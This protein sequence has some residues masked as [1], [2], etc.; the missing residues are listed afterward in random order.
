[1]KLSNIQV[2]LTT[3]NEELR[4]H[5]VLDHLCRHCSNIL[6]IDNLSTDKTVEILSSCYPSVNVRTLKNNGTSETAEW[7]REARRS[8][9]LDY[10]VFASCSEYLPLE[11]LQL[12]NFYAA[13]AAVQYIH[14]PRSSFTNGESLDDLYIT[15]SS[16][17]SREARLPYV[18]RCVYVDAVDPA[19][20]SPHDAFRSQ[21]RGQ[22]LYVDDYSGFYTIV[23]LRP[24]P[25]SG[26]FKKHVAYAKNYAKLKFQHKPLSAFLDTF[27]R[28]ILDTLRLI[29]SIIIRHSLHPIVKIE[30]NARVFMHINVFIFAVLS[31]LPSSWENK[32]LRN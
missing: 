21:T 11:L 31:C 30:Y 9:N 10:V 18:C 12:Y 24:L 32:L 2:V 23:H 22:H 20:I 25:S 26:L 13:Q 28:I 1:M 3:Y 27:L 19:L 16:L 8:F 29:R 14:V 5:S 7:W 15:P 6:V 4:V 17:L